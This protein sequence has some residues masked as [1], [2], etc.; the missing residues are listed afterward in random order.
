VSVPQ[1]ADLVRV[2]VDV[3]IE[4]IGQARRLGGTRSR[5]GSSGGHDDIMA[6]RTAQALA[7]A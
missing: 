3:G 2:E 1:L 4:D 7:A 6:D 5:S